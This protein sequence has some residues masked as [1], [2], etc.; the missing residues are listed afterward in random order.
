MVNDTVIGRVG[1]IIEMRKRN[2]RRCRQM[3]NNKNLDE[4]AKNH[5]QRELKTEQNCLIDA[6]NLD[7]LMAAIEA[8]F[9]EIKKEYCQ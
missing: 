7:N 5:I 9:D 2:I 3:L 8:E 4:C 1:T 6:M